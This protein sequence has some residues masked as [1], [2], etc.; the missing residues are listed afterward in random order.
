LEL[1][2]LKNYLLLKETHGIEYDIKNYSMDYNESFFN[3]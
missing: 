2:K 1:N 3:Y